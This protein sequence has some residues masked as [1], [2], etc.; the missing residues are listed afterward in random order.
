MVMMQVSVV[1]QALWCPE[2]PVEL[3]CTNIVNYSRYTVHTNTLHRCTNQD[4]SA[5]VFSYGRLWVKMSADGMMSP[6]GMQLWIYQVQDAGCSKCSSDIPRRQA[7]GRLP[8]PGGKS[9]LSSNC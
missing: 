3:L 9:Q 4:F 7:D 2:F 6:V 5:S 8:R 1:T